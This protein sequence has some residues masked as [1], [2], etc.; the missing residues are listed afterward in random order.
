MTTDKIFDILSASESHVRGE[1]IAE[2]LGITRTAVNKHIRK[3]QN[4]GI[5]IDATRRGYKYISTDTLTSIT[6][7]SRIASL[8]LPI[9]VIVEEVESTNNSVKALLSNSELKDKNILF[10]APK[11]LRGRGRLGREFQSSE[12]GVY[13]TLCYSPN[14]LAVTDSLKIVLLTGLCVAR[15]L[16]KYVPNVSIKWPNDVFIDD[17]KVS[18]ILLESV[19]NE[20]LAEKIILGIG[21]NVSNTISDSLSHIATSLSMH[22][23]DVCREDIIVQV[24]E[25]LFHELA[26]YEKTGFDT[27]ISEYMALSR[28]IGYVVTVSAPNGS[29]TGKAVGLSEEGNLLIDNNGKIEKIIVGD[30]EV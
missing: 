30:V 15:V 16:S 11:Q 19:V 21:I 28:T 29:I 24:T 13:M 6:L 5:N 4:Q 27:F 25:M 7:S 9:T 22:G 2:A 10:V 1:L 18:G 8:K 3:L 20:Y 17:R 23:V 12:G 26:V 14:N